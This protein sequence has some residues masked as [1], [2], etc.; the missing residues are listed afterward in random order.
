MPDNRKRHA[1]TSGSIHISGLEGCNG[2]AGAKV[3]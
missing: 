2:S 3:F 1:A